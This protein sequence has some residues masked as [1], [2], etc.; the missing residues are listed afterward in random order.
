MVRK[1]IV[2]F[3]REYIKEHEYAPT[4]REIACGLGYKSLTTV[5]HHMNILFEQG[6]LETDLEDRFSTSRAYRIARQK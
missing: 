5:H 1:N 3:I 4:Y 6:A 2:E